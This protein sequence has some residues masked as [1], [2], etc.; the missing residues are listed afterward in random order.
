M[1]RVTETPAERTARWRLENH[2]RYMDTKW[3]VKAR[4]KLK[5]AEAALNKKPKVKTPEES[6]HTLEKYISYHAKYR[7]DNAALLSMKQKAYREANSEKI[8]ALQQARYIRDKDKHLAAGAA[9]R[10]ANAD[11]I[12]NTELTILISYTPQIKNI[13]RRTRI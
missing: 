11:K 7:E 9:Y 3:K 4:H 12:K 13:A 8:K 6:A 10:V 2:G 5:F 1:S